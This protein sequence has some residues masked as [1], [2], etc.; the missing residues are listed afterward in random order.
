MVEQHLAKNKC[1]TNVICTKPEKVL[2][3]YADEF[4]HLDLLV[5]EK[6]IAD[7]SDAILLFDESPGSLCEL[8]A[9][10]ACDPICHILTAFIPSKYYGESSFAM[11]GP[12]KHLEAD[13]GRLSGVIYGDVECPTSSLELMQYLSSLRDLSKASKQ[14]NSDASKISIGAYCLE[15]LD[16][17]SVFSPLTIAEL[18]RTYCEYKRFDGIVAFDRDG[19]LGEDCD[20][21]NT[22]LLVYFLAA[23]D[24]V[25]Y[26]DGIITMTGKHAGYFMFNQSFRRQ[27]MKL[28]AR[29]LAAKRRGK[30]RCRNVRFGSDGI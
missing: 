12:V 30:R 21:I 26:H 17:I 14:K 4:S 1:G 13:C 5:L 8:G 15:L 2:A 22:E 20:K 28:R 19:C 7:V 3:Q 23:C 6:L 29:E 16:L 25:K 24:L 27:I 18:E 10:S 11:N 9:F